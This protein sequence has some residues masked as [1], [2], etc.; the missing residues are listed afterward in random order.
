MRDEA[1][2]VAL[3]QALTEIKNISPGVQASFLIDKEGKVIASDTK[4]SEASFEKTI[5]ALESLLEKTG[6]IGGLDS[7]V[8]NAQKGK[9][10]IS[11][12]SDMYL[13]M[14]T[15]EN[16]DMAYL[17]T[18]SR[19]LILTVMKLLDNIT[20]SAAP[21]K[22]QQS[23]P[24]LVNQ[25]KRIEQQTEVEEAS[26]EEINK[27]E[28][29]EETEQPESPVLSP[30][31]KL[32]RGLHEGTHQLVVETIGG[33]LVRG[34]MVEI[35]SD[36]LNGWSDSYNGAHISSVE[37]KSFS[38]K[39]VV[40]KVRPQKDSNIKGTGI[41]RVTEKTCRDLDVKKGELVRVKPHQWEE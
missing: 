15:S 14:I 22:P 13:A 29:G 34:D 38:G 1:H 36:V 9:V 8:I 28:I 17:Q 6:A 40:C 30:A 31:P 4:S 35:D 41:I 33:L 37:I 32:H 16:V 12:V 19:V 21:I 26:A 10:R 7:L 24:S 18:I 3:R 27:E 5:T 39:S 2:S 20:P 11:S 25:P 23:K